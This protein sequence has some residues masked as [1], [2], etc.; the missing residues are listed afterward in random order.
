MR[1]LRNLV[2][3]LIG[4]VV[5]AAIAVFFLL[6]SIDFNQYRPLI[7][8]EVRRLTGRDLEIVGDLKLALSLRPTI[9]V[10]DVRFANAMWGSRRDMARIDSLRAVIELLPLM[11]GA[12]R[13]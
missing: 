9:E 12:L 4:L 11:S 7:Q 10:H 5:A 3:C 13:I 1:V 8:A 2:L 6:Q